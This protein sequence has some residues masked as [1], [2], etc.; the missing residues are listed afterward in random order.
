MSRA[1]AANIGVLLAS[2]ML[3]GCALLRPSPAP[4]PDADARP[5]LSAET[6]G[7]S[8]LAR[9]VVSAAFADQAATLQCVVDVTP[10]HMTLVALNAMG[11]RLFSVVV[12]GG[13]TLAERSPGVPAAIQ[14]ERILADIQ[15]AYWPL[16]ALQTAYAG[17]RWSVSEPVAGTRRLLHDGRLAEEVHYAQPGGNRWQGRL[18]LANFAQGYSL[19][20]DSQ[21]MS[22]VP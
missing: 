16:A 10:E 14:P 19:S 17:T 18:W 5:I 20:V 3:S 13:K 21:P 9:Q 8:Q 7:G 1:G 4:A 11:L 6:L 2:L 22:R 15:L 12:A